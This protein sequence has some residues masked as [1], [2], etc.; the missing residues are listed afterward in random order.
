MSPNV[1]VNSST[2]DMLVRLMSLYNAD[3]QCI[4]YVSHHCMLPNHQSY[5]RYVHDWFP[6]PAEQQHCDA[7]IASM[8]FDGYKFKLATIQQA[9]SKSVIFFSF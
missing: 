7:P 9:K 8:G 1:D 5:H 4:E 3:V 6:R 2:C